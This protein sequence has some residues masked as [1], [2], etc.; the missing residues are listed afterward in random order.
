[1]K[2]NLIIPCIDNNHYAA[3]LQQA[4]AK[5]LPSAQSVTVVTSASD[6]QTTLVAS[7][8]GCLIHHTE[9][10]WANGAVFNKGAA[11]EE[12]RSQMP[13]NNWILLADADVVPPDSWLSIIEA[14]NP[15][16]G[17]LY[18]ARRQMDDGTVK[19]DWNQPQGFFQLFHV[20]DPAA[21]ARPLIPTDWTHAGG[22][23]S[24]L[25]NR[26]L[27]KRRVVI[28]EL[29]LRHHGPDGKHWCGKGNDA[30]MERLMAERN[31]RPRGKNEKIQVRKQ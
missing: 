2:V 9:V 17:F 15:Q 11:M 26:W 29:I 8:A 7:A 12:A 13:W 6:D 23:D 5:W 18:G 3:L 31:G 28:N 24:D 20:D 27:P 19:N 14:R 16:C 4:L 21:Q 30:A 1:M 22:Y 10:W 25:T